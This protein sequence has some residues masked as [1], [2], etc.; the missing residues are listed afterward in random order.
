DGVGACAAYKVERA[1]NVWGADQAEAT[2]REFEFEDPAD[3]GL[4]VDG[5][6]D[7]RLGCGH[8]HAKSP[9][10]IIAQARMRTGILYVEP[11][12]ES[13]RGGCEQPAGREVDVKLPGPRVGEREISARRAPAVSVCR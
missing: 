6:D 9:P 5:K 4:I 3:A 10:P 8:S 13:G 11:G 1:R 2:S 12:T 7:E